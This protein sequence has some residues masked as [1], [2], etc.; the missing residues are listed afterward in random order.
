MHVIAIDWSGAESGAA[1][2]I[3]LAEVVDGV[4]VRLENGRSRAALAAHLLDL[5]ARV[6]ELVVGLDFAFA[7]PAWFARE[8]GATSGPALWA[9]AEREG[10]GWLCACAPPFWG[11]A[12]RRPVPSGAGHPAVT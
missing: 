11:R 3:W 5:G 6:R 7:F 12:G 9:L 8:H 1:R 10:D 2:R 4:L